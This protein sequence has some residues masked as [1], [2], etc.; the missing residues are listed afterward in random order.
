MSCPAS[1]KRRAR[2]SPPIRACRHLSFTG[3][4]AVGALVQEAAARH[5]AP[6][7]LELG[8][9]SPQLVFADADLERALPFLVNAGI[10]NAGQTCSASSR[11]LVERKIYG[12]VVERMAARYRTLK[13]GPADAD[14][15]VGPLISERQKSIVSRFIAEGADLRNGRRPPRSSRMRRGADTMSPRPCSPMSAHSPPR[16]GGNLRPRPGRHSLRGRGRGDRNRQRDRLRP[17]RWRLDGRR[18]AADAARQGAARRAGV[19]QQLRRGRRRRAAV[20]RRGQ[21]GSWPREGI[22]GAVRFLGAEDR[23]GVAR[24]RRNGATCLAARACL[25]CVIALDG[26]RDAARG[27]ARHSRCDGV[28]WV[29]PD[30]RWPADGCRRR[31]RRRAANSDVDRRQPAG[32]GRGRRGTARSCARPA[33]RANVQAE[34]RRNGI[35]PVAIGEWPG[36]GWGGVQ[37]YPPGRIADQTNGRHRA[38]LTG[39]MRGARR[40][41]DVAS[42]SLILRAPQAARSKDS[43]DCAPFGAGASFEA[44]SRRLRTR[45]SGGIA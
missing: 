33:C 1:G 6:V 40:V 12:E 3:S 29:G 30:R 27:Q 34:L 26:L 17:R 19:P 9:K 45:P 22:S 21:I 44:A 35:A 15:D 37:T 8:G 5:V 2:R 43:P 38:L 28:A 25:C 24:L 7:T 23:R 32:G 11:I 13:V 42:H 18:R 36:A 10:Q 4:V 14:L 41:K 31:G 20:R 16:P 39:G